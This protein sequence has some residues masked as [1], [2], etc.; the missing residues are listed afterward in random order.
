[1]VAACLVLA[2]A[3]KEQGIVLAGLV[4]VA[5][6]LVPSRP[7]TWRERL[8]AAAPGYLLLG[9]AGIGILVGRYVVLGDLGGGP[10]AKGLD[11]LTLGER[12]IAMLP[13][14]LE[15]LRLLVWPSGLAAQYS[16]PGYAEA[17][18]HGGHRDRNPAEGRLRHQRDHA[19]DR[20]HQPDAREE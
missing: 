4:V 5:D 10:P 13:I 9:V 7:G 6:L 17:E 20:Q 11:G 2:A 14:T 8:R 18:E 12:T 19:A 3:A 15:W 16:P 1:M